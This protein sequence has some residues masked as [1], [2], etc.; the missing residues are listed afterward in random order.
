[1][2]ARRNAYHEQL[3]SCQI[4]LF[5]NHQ[6]LKAKAILLR[7]EKAVGWSGW[8]KKICIFRVEETLREVY[9]QKS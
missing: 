6:L 8:M 2:L 5:Y 9:L 3:I 7:M 1:M 4:F